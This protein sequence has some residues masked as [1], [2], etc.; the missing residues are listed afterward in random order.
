LQGESEIQALYPVIFGADEDE[1]WTDEKVWKKANPSLGIT[2]DI[3]KLRLACNSAKQNPAEENIF[4]QLR[5]NQWVKQS[6]RW[7]P[8]EKW[9]A[10]SFPVSETELLGRVCYAGLDLSSTTDL[11]LL[12]WFFLR[13]RTMSLILSFRIFGYRKR[14]YRLG[15]AEIMCRMTSGKKKA[16]FLRPKAMLCTTVLSRNLLKT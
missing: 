4:R 12:S 10:C 9:D 11:T 8:M 13:K 14:M 5:L 16:S 2:V 3:E 1:D 15:S 6:V 7:M